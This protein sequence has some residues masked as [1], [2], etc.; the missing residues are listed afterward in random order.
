VDEHY[1]KRPDPAKRVLFTEFCNVLRK[2]DFI[3]GHDTE[4]GNVFLAYGKDVIQALIDG[5]T[6]FVAP[7][8]V[9]LRQATPEL[10]L[11]LVT[12]DQV[13]GR[14]D[15]ESYKG[16]AGDAVEWLEKLVVLDGMT[17]TKASL[18]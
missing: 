4:T 10:E 5:K 14:N 11:L 3:F 15:Y 6:Q 8:L 13:K 9:N 17:R 1:F 18:T 16:E 7:I 12:L 2:A